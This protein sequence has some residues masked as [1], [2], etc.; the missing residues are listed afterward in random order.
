MVGYLFI[1]ATTL[2]SD[3]CR[4]PSWRLLV[5]LMFKMPPMSYLASTWMDISTHLAIVVGYI[6]V[7][8]PV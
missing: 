6:P 5:S 4:E 3:K 2:R 7:K 1:L 8:H